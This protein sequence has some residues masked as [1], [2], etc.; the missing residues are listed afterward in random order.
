MRQHV[1][2][3]YT[4]TEREQADLERERDPPD[5]ALSVAGQKHK[6]RSWIACAMFFA[7]LGSLIV[8]ANWR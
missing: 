4:G 1:Q 3:E 2:S 7:T 5:E 8:M 6:R